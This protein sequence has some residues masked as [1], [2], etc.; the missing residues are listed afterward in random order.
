MV[1]DVFG[2]SHVARGCETCPPVDLQHVSIPLVHVVGLLSGG[3]LHAHEAEHGLVY[4]HAH[5]RHSIV[6][7]VPNGADPVETVRFYMHF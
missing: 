3:K 4:R 1:V 5:D 6:A 7:D 2:L